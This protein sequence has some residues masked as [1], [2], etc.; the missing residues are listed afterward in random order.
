MVPVAIALHNLEETL[1]LP[2][3][4]NSRTDRWHSATR[5]FPFRFAVT[6]LTMAAVTIACYAQQGGSSGLG[7]YILAAYALGQS[8]NIFMP[9]LI[10]TIA[11]R[12]YMPGLATGIAFVLPAS[13]VFLVNAFSSPD[14]DPRRFFIVSLVFIP[15]MLL[16]I[17]LLFRIGQIIERR[18]SV[19]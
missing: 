1:W 14:F 4:S 3:W 15:L 2:A 10:G 7:F 6:I 19:S 18:V 17:P 13:G 12:T 16:S 8:M 9:H 11:T 5:A